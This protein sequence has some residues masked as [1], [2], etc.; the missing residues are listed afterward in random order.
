MHLVP[1]EE[2]PCAV[3]YFSHSFHHR[4]MAKQIL[5]PSKLSLKSVHL[6][7]ALFGLHKEVQHQR[8]CGVARVFVKVFHT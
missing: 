7:V 2:G 4:K 6:I 1:R 8:L 5:L 3:V